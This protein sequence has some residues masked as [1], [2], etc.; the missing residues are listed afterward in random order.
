MRPEYWIGIMAVVGAI[1]GYAI[2]RQTGWLGT[3]IGIVIGIL[4]G[5]V[6]YAG[7]KNRQKSTK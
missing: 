2:F 7:L 6:I 3:G 1:I 5:V 4:I